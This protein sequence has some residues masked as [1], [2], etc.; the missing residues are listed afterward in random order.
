VRLLK[1]YI[2]TTRLLHIFHGDIQPFTQHLTI[3]QF[4][5]IFIVMCARGGSRN[6]KFD[7]GGRQ[8]AREKSKKGVD[9]FGNSGRVF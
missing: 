8:V 9:F 4:T 6:V 7:F 5:H 3:Q 1:D 2:P